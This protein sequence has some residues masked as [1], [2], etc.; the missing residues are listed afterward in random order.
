MNKLVV[1]GISTIALSPRSSAQHGDVA[2]VHQ[3]WN[4]QSRG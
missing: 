4:G 3:P 1:I 2:L